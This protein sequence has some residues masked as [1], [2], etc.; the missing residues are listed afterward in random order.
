ML[1]AQI[2]QVLDLAT[3]IIVLVSTTAN[4][5]TGRMNNDQNNLEREKR[6]LME[7]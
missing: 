7:N 4:A 1:A 2:D 5:V 3:D 6:Y